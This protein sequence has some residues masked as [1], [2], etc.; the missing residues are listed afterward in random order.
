MKKICL[1]DSYKTHLFYF[2][3]KHHENVV[4][5]QKWC[6]T[7]YFCLCRKVTWLRKSLVVFTCLPSKRLSKLV[8]Y[9]MSPQWQCN[10]CIY[11]ADRH[12]A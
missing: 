12:Y 9:V 6:Y 5:E 3:I 8:T 2:L 4:F 10:A 1:Y 7:C 11:T